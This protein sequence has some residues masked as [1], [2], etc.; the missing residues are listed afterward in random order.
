MPRRPSYLPTVLERLGLEA[1]RQR[2][3]LPAGVGRGTIA[4]MIEKSWIE[5]TQAGNGVRAF[6]V[7]EEGIEALKRKFPEKR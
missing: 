2:R 1:I 6:S 7:T 4:A 5:E 3:A